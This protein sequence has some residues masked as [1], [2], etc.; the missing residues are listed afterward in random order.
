MTPSLLCPTFFSPQLLEEKRELV[1][2][3]AQA[4][5]EKEVLGSDELERLLGQRPFRSLELRNIDKFREG[6][7]GGAAA[8][9][10]Q[11]PGDGKSWEGVRGLGGS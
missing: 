2:A 1:E 11:Q 5:L 8:R 9:V 3:M 6:F 4:L 7:D 10:S